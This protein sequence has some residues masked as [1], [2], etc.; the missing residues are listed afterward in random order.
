MPNTLLE[1]I[2]FKHI[3]KAKLYSLFTDEMFGINILTHDIGI[4]N[5]VHVARFDAVMSNIA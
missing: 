5:C 2:L 1:S 3:C 4:C